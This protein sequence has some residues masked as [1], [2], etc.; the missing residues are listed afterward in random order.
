MTALL[1]SDGSDRAS[2][3]DVSIL[4]MGEVR[5]DNPRTR[6]DA[7]YFSRLAVETQRC[8]ETLPH[9][10]LG[11]QCRVFR[12]GIFDIKADTY[13]SSG[14][15]FVR[16]GNL[17]DGL[18]DVR[19]IAHISREAHEA[20]AETALRFGDFVL[21]KTAYAGAALVTVPEC[22]V[23]QDVIAARLSLAGREVLNSGYVVAFLTCRYG[24]ALMQ[25]QFQGNV[26]E[27]LALEDGRGL[28]VP[29]FGMRFQD[30]VNSAVLSS[31]RARTEAQAR[32]GEADRKVAEILDVDTWTV[33][34]PVA[35]VQRIRVAR[36]AERLDA[37]YHHPAKRACVELL[38]EM[39]G[40]EL[41]IHYDSVRELFDPRR[42]N[43]G[44][45]VR[46]FDLSDALAPVLDDS[47]TP[48]DAAGIKSMKKRLM[49]GDLVTS[50][51][52][53]YLR[54]TALVRTSDET[55]AVGSTEF[56]VLR[57][58][59]GSD[60]SQ[61]AL[62]VFLRSLPVQTILRWSQDGSHHPRYD[63]DDLLQIPVPGLVR[64]A[65][66]EI[67]DCVD[68]AL[69]ARAESRMLLERAK[70]AVEIAIEQS[71]AA[72]IASLE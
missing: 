52:R 27:H 44:E 15:P 14:V 31:H 8:L 4:R 6:L 58:R 50:R 54:E 24:Q 35:Y 40:T 9:V 29:K 12:K 55:S 67:A 68:D 70:R 26:Q 25:R 19:G 69:E 72:G 71:E 45:V 32:L 38:R 66:D 21:S 5:K 2:A 43:P 7:G 16:I 23:S 56:L 28:V 48:T 17:D 10:R 53:A 1:E 65:S 22:N 36:A 18:L 39:D 61:A 64:D 33:P 13:A 59:P 42:A 20:S 60:L 51:L 57:K 46:N 3:I 34:D 63:G 62:L 30:A 11:A 47:K 37:E 41:G 49:F